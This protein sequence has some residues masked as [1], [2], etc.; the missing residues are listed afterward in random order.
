MRN[1][2]RDSPM[3][4]RCAPISPT[5]PVS[6]AKH[7][8]KA[9][10]SDLLRN[11]LSARTTNPPGFATAPAG[12]NPHIRSNPIIPN[13]TPACNG[14]FGRHRPLLG[15]SP[16][17][18]VQETPLSRKSGPIS[19]RYGPRIHAV[20]AEVSVP[21]PRR[22]IRPVPPW[23]PTRHRRRSVRRRQVLG[24]QGRPDQCRSSGQPP[25]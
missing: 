20:A 2:C 22:A 9:S 8:A 15:F 18:A 11:L 14:I 16:G 1:G 3:Q 4:Q 19:I 6:A 13:Q 17:Q 21:Q 12:P 7:R 10:D 24:H 23:S 5:H 25:H